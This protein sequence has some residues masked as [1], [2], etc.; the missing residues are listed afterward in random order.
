MFAVYDTFNQKIV[1]RHKT[2]AAA[3]KA[4]LK[5]QRAVKKAN[6][7]TSYLPTELRVVASDGTLQRVDED[8]HEQEEWLLCR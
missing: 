1:S 2:V 6:G 4:D 3:I 5:L 7:K 8:S